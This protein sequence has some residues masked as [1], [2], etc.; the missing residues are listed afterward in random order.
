M[1]HHARFRSL[2]FAS[3]LFVLLL[4]VASP[5]A[6]A[7]A[8]PAATDAADPQLR[9]AVPALIAGAVL[10]VPASDS[11]MVIDGVL[12]EAAWD[13]A[14]RL[15][16]EYETRPAENG[17]APVATELFLT[18]DDSNFY[19][20]FRAEDPHPEAIVARLAD[21]DTAFQDDFV[22][23]AVDT[24]NDERRAFEFFVNPLGV[25]M[26]LIYD[27]VNGSEDESWDGIWSSAG[28]LTASG[29]TVEM[30]I[31]YSTLRFPKGGTTQ[32][33]GIDAVR[34]Y[35]RGDRY[36]LSI[37]P[38]Q[39]GRN[40]YLCQMTKIEGFHG[41]SPGKNLEITPTLT[42]S[43][44]DTREDFPDGGFVAGDTEADAGL[45][46]TW[47]ITPNVTLSGTLNP[48]FSQVEADAAQLD[49][50]ETFA[51]F[52]P[53]R[54]PF[55]LEGAELFNTPLNA[56]FTRN[57]ADPSW[58]GKVTGKI[59]KN[60]IGAFAAQDDRTNLLFPGSQGSDATSLELQTTDSVVRYRRDVG[61]S[62]ALG[63]LVTSRSGGGY[64]NL[65]YGFD[66][67][68]RVNDSH[69]FTVQALQSSTEYP[70]AVAAEFDQPTGKFDDHAI[71]AA[72]D[73][74]TRDWRGYARYEEVGPGF[75]ADMGFL[76]RVG[77]DMWVAGGSRVWY[78]EDGDWYNDIRFGGD[79]DV[80]TDSEGQELER[81]AE[82][83]L[84]Y[85]GPRQSYGW[86]GLVHRK[87]FFNG[88]DFTESTWG[89]WGEMRPNGNLFVGLGIYGG[90][91]I[92]FTNTRP[93]ERFSLEP[94]L[95]WNLGR[96]LKANLNHTYQRLDIDGGTLFT[97]NLS[98][99]RLTYQ[100]N[101]RTFARLVLQNTDIS[102][103]VEL[104]N[105]PEGVE[106]E[107]QR[108]F[109][110]LLGSYKINPRTVLFVGYSDNYRGDQVVDLTQ[111]DRALFVKVGYAWVL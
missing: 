24:F 11:E 16:L 41:A 91:A 104:Y 56:V 35:P 65:V 19:V 89:T 38:Q 57:V 103:T 67:L 18:F 30:A 92:D 105:D 58:G 34:F 106:A 47:G 53:E 27:D 71:R 46:A 72:Y 48:D 74:G 22:G 25:Q 62:S 44:R 49:I 7:A 110:Q 12:S 101:L 68:Y 40:C 45:T 36:R 32:R 8:A 14:L 79:Y 70:G 84:N 83:N 82:V 77:Y 33:W 60:V 88:V 69:S 73:Y 98:Q 108:L 50:N 55:F 20:A 94:T 59:G 75:R 78:G 96:H 107:S 90:D 111:T 28:K 42:A 5:G 43:R 6:R 17:P 63:G 85:S 29:Y 13:N 81:E 37:L 64:S 9:A 52:F 10:T 102:R 15:P 109:T 95:T 51:L 2:L 97:A 99:L 3:A 61:G 54:R 31:P 76:P 21:R 39:R 80:T 93:A 87:R 4:P 1:H 100:F 26:D 23:V 66:G 86:I